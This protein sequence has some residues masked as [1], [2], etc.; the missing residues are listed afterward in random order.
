MP[1]GSIASDLHQIGYDQRR[2]VATYEFL[3]ANDSVSPVAAYAYVDSRPR[4]GMMSW[5]AMTIAPFAAVAV[6]VDVAVPEKVSERRRLVIEVHAD[7]AH[8]TLDATP[9]HITSAQTI[10]R[11]IVAG[12]VALAA[13]ALAL[14]FALG[15]P[16]IVAL[17][18]PRFATAGERIDVAY[19]TA[20]AGAWTYRLQRPDGFQVRAGSVPGGNGAFDVVLPQSGDTQSYD[21]MLSGGTRIAGD[22]RTAHIVAVP[23][24]KPVAARP[25][26]SVSSL[27]LAREVVQSGAPII[28]TYRSDA[29]SGIVQLVDG[30][31]DVRAEGPFSK[32]GTTTLTAP[33][34]KRD[35]EFEL[36]VRAALG[37]SVAQSSIGVVVRSSAPLL[38]DIPQ[39]PRLQQP[40]KN[41]PHLPPEGDAPFALPASPIVGGSPIDIA[42]VSERPGLRLTLAT[43]TGTELANSDVRAGQRTVLLPAPDV[44]RDTRFLIEAAYPSPIGEETIIRPIVVH[45]RST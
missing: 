19:A 3:L 21:L 28:A 24:A 44:A 32:L 40:T 34:V 25:E 11:R 35:E 45:P 27:R 4:G 31:G 18:A 10:R 5:N 41:V 16:R 12:V 26:A 29:T 13:V 17:A 2:R 8:L 9:P 39:D 43:E 42:I 23:P 20:G 1:S 22:T 37:R 30:G 33:T 7:M 14:G 36:V 15:R 6:T 38:A